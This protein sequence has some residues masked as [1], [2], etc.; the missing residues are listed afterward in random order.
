MSFP[1]SRRHPRTL[2][3]AF[4]PYCS[5]QVAP[6]RSPETR[7]ERVA[8]W[9]LAIAIGVSLGVLLVIEIAGG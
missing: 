1:T 4:G 7:A 2:Q 3:E 6:M 9:L 5:S 8:G